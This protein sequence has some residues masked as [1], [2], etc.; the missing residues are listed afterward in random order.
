MHLQRIT[1]TINKNLLTNSKYI[2]GITKACFEIKNHS[3]IEE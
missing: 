2:N 1:L 3:D